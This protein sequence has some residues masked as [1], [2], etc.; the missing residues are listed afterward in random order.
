VTD[1]VGFPTVFNRY[2]FMFHDG[3]TL[4]VVAIHDD[5]DLR[6][7]VVEQHYGAKPNAKGFDRTWR[8]VG[9]TDLG[10][11]FTYTPHAPEPAPPGGDDAG[12]GVGETNEATTPPPT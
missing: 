12:S 2:R 6:A 3:E 10:A 4:D 8:I 5:S 11:V 1:A 9:S 7:W